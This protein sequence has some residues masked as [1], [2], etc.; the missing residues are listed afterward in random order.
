[1]HDIFQ[2]LIDLGQSAGYP[3]LASLMFVNTTLGFPPSELICFGFGA[4]AARSQINVYFVI[5]VATIFNLLG[6]CCWYY[7]ARYIG[8]DKINNVFTR[9]H[10]SKFNKLAS[11]FG[12]GQNAIS[13]VYQAYENYGGHI[14]LFGRNIPIIRSVVSIPAGVTQ[15]SSLKFIFLSLIG[16][17]I[18]VTLWC[19]LGYYIVYDPNSIKFYSTIIAFIVTFTVIRVLQKHRP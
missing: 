6:T 2:K 17:K 8:K 13:K 19:L 11:L 4:L 10:Q 18:W 14:V 15:M 12:F 16:I 5:I 3:G 7:I 1:M 9:L